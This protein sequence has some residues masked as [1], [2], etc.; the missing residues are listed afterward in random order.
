MIK[1]PSLRVSNIADVAP[2]V[3]DELQHD[4]EWATEPLPFK[5][6]EFEIPGGAAK[7]T[8][9]FHSDLD[10]NLRTEDCAMARRLWREQADQ[11]RVALRRLRS[12]WDKWGVRFDVMLKF[13][14]MRTVT[15]ESFYALK[16]RKHYR[17]EM[18]EDTR[19]PRPPRPRP[20]YLWIDEEGIEHIGGE[21]YPEKARQF[22]Q[23][24]GAKFQRYL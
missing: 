4:F 3:L 11:T 13:H 18:K 1:D 16:E 14:D 21:P 24:Y 2:E 7:G 23:R 19:G 22:E 8:F 17:P 12:L 20:S 9:G 5:V 10:V 6:L 15:D